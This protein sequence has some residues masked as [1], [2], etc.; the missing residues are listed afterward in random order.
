M[1]VLLKESPDYCKSC[2]NFFSFFVKDNQNAI[3]FLKF[4]ET[5]CLVT[6]LKEFYLRESVILSVTMCVVG[7]S[8][9][10][11]ARRI[12]FRI[13]LASRGDGQVVLWEDGTE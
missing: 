9:V 4:Y 13:I 8:I 6:F 12:N 10:L 2:C 5:T 11:L 1:Q 7:N 3:P